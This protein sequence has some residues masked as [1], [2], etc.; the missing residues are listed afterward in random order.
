[1]LQQPG[2]WDTDNPP[3]KGGIEPRVATAVRIQQ[4]LCPQLEAHRR[5]GPQVLRKAEL[6]ERLYMTPAHLHRI[7]D[8]L[9]PMTLLQV[10][11]IANLLGL[12]SLTWE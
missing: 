3:L 12:E 4:R 11:A 8:G 2:A 9:A 5:S 7:T 10:C 6:A 1:M